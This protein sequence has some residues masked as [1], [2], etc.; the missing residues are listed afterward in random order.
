MNYELT[1]KN[2]MQT[3]KKVQPQ[4]HDIVKNEDI[5]H[6]S[7]HI[8]HHNEANINI[9]GKLLYPEND[10]NNAILKQVDNFIHKPTAYTSKPIYAEANDS[11]AML[12]EKYIKKA[13]DISPYLYKQNE[14]HG[15]S[16]NKSSI[17]FMIMLGVGNAQHII[18][19]I[20]KVDIKHMIIVDEDFSMFKLSLHISDWNIIFKHFFREGY[21]LNFRVSNKS[22]SDLSSTIINTIF[23]QN[24]FSRYYL[25]Y[26]THYE[27]NFFKEV[28]QN[29]SEKF[30]H[31]RLGLGFIDDEITSISHTIQN[32]KNKRPLLQKNNFISS[33]KSVFIIGS[34][35][36]IDNDIKYI[37]KHKNNV[38]II[39]GG[40]SLAILKENNIVPDFHFEMER[41]DVT[42]D[43]LVRTYSKE[44]L[45]QINIIGLNLIYPDTFSLFKNAY[46][47]CRDNDSGAALLGS[48]YPQ[49][50]HCNPTVVN[51]MFSFCCYI[52]FEN[53]YLFGVD[54]GYISE[55]NHHS[56]YSGYYKG[57]VE[58]SQWKPNTTTEIQSNFNDKIILTNEVFIWNK[59]RLENA[60]VDYCI[61]Q[62][63]KINI[64]NCSDG[65]LIRGV[66]PMHS[67]KIIIKEINKESLLNEITNCFEYNIKIDKNLKS[68]FKIEQNQYNLIINSIINIINKDVNNISELLGNISKSRQLITNLVT[69]DFQSGISFSL[70][71]GTIDTFYSVIYSHT[72]GHLN[73]KEAIEFANNAM[74]ILIEFL[75]Q[76]KIEIESFKKDLK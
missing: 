56:K 73:K 40:S 50:Q 3:L 36:S 9:N 24:P 61:R 35:P 15:Y 43:Y 21:S 70:L 30:M 62:D 74:K 6:L 13:L 5:S 37:K 18:S 38:L 65:A 76:A 46:L 63:K 28:K 19:L 75:K 58:L 29:L 41:N 23:L 2:N 72:L 55:E 39:A 57:D 32:V 60:I 52:G 7:L 31:T 45:E 20:S 1:Y 68:N 59:Q 17:Y 10:I 22:A 71:R 14:F 53:I 4:L 54:M 26:Y 67:N 47:F 12:H 44:Y 49:L 42:R 69:K 27:S 8:N 25:P 66:S 48:K 33:K 16:H 64:F 34:G 11:Y 51:M